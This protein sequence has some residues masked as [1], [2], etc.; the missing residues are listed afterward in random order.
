MRQWHQEMTNR[1]TLWAFQLRQREG[2]LA[3]ALSLVIGAVVGVVIVAFIALTGRIAQHFYPTGAADWRRIAMPIIGALV[4]GWMLVRWFPRARGSGIPQTKSAFFLRDG[5]I[6]GKTV[7]GKFLCC[8]VSL[9]S[10]ISLGREGP[11]VQI[12]AGIA[13]VIGQR[14][15]LSRQLVRSLVPVGAAAALAAAFNTPIA[16]VLFSLEEVAGDL[17]APVLGGVVLSSATSWMVLH[18]LLGDTP[19]FHVVPYH[20][21][22]NIE[23]VG[24]AFLGVAG[25]LV[26]VAFVKLLLWLR[27]WFRRWAASTEWAQPMVGGATVG[28]MAFFVPEVLG[29]GYP[30]VGHILAGEMV[31]KVVVMLL[32]LKVVATAVCYASGNAGGI[33]GPALFMGATCGAAV[34]HLLHAIA[35]GHTAGAGAFALVGMGT[36]FAGVVRTPMTSVIMIFE[37]T[38]DYAII[39]P[40]MISN[41]I[42]FFIS[43]QLQPEPVY[44]A[45][46]HQDGIHLP[47]SVARDVP[48]HLRVGNA[49]QRVVDM[50]PLLATA[51]VPHVH[52]D[53]PLS[54]A[55]ERLAQAPDGVLPVVSRADVT[56]VLGTITLDDAL[57]GYRLKE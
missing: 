36:V 24:Y 2:Q 49:M 48:S 20:L 34:G 42:A 22:H 35:P 6:S 13:S 44:V 45:L 51:D 32:I 19:L 4:S 47:H 12:G 27:L 50:P 14:L 38:R 54:V 25:G 3:M 26:S 52:P 1:V 21:D 10:G 11:S 28:V 39:V 18:L 16:A 31:L 41:L 33:F 40:L 46:A 37:L 8:S 53:Q 43:Q 29:V 56:R 55:L 9:G 15:G 7:L 23:F 57:R 17:H 30:T 5:V